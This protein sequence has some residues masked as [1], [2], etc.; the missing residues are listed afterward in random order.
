MES[1]DFILEKGLLRNQ[2]G[3]PRRHSAG[4]T[5][6]HLQDPVQANEI[7]DTW[8]IQRPERIGGRISGRRDVDRAFI[9]QK[10]RLRERER[11]RLRVQM[12]IFRMALVQIPN[13]NPNLNPNHSLLSSSHNEYLPRPFRPYRAGQSR[14]HTKQ[15][16]FRCLCCD[17][18]AEHFGRTHASFSGHSSFLHDLMDKAG[19]DTNHAKVNT[20]SFHFVYARLAL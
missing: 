6:E 3:I 8:R 2:E 9:L 14:P 18:G 16:A 4:P 1:K 15:R 19:I 7:K 17:G 12:N 10:D 5:T 13:T 20:A 11:E